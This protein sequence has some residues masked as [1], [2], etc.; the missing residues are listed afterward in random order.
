MRSYGDA[1]MKLAGYVEDPDDLNIIQKSYLS[2][3]RSSLYKRI[4]KGKGGRIQWDYITGKRTRH[5]DGRRIWLTDK[6]TK[7]LEKLVDYYATDEGREELEKYD[8]HPIPEHIDDLMAMLDGAPL[9]RE[10]KRDE[11]RLFLK[12]KDEIMQFLLR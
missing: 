2:H 9:D 11:F 3:L 12:Y 8:I 6:N 4:C 1:L 7:I 5:A 10:M